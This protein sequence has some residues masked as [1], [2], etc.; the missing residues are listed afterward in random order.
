MML[1][2]TNMHEFGDAEEGG[3]RLP[4]LESMGCGCTT[5]STRQHRILP[6][7][8]AL[9][10][11]SFLVTVGKEAEQP[12]YRI[13]NRWGPGSEVYRRMRCHFFANCQS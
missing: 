2:G 12:P 5:P 6:V 1:K 13:E 11:A 8:V 4:T 7:E 3:C 9:N 10:G